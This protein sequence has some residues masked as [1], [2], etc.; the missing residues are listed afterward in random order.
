MTI[1]LVIVVLIVGFL[2]YVSMKPNAFR[3]ERSI[4]IDAP[5]EKVFPLIND[6]HNWTQWSPWENVD[7]DLKRDYSGS[8]SGLGAVYG[9]EGK[10][11]GMGRME[12]TESTP[13]S[14]VLIK[15][16]FFKPFEAHNTADF[17]ITA[18]GGQSTVLWAMYGPQ[19]FMTKLMGTF[20]NMDKMLGS[21]FEQGLA[22]MKRVAEGS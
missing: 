17:S 7:A 13:S 15:L 4:T 5:A 12:I 9:W 11:T 1:A 18:S 6:F 20:M 19:P 22:S 10:K 14:R 8:P 16:D 2:V 3:Y 21:T